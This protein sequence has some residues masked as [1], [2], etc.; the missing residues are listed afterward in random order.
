[1]QSLFHPI[2]ESSD[3]SQREDTSHLAPPCPT[4]EA[5]ECVEIELFNAIPVEVP[6]PLILTGLTEGMPKSNGFNVSVATEWCTESAAYL[7]RLLSMVV[8]LTLSFG[9]WLCA[10]LAQV[11]WNVRL[12]IV[13]VAAL[14]F[15]A[16]E[17]G[18]FLSNTSLGESFSALSELVEVSDNGVKFSFITIRLGGE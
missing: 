1:M 14:A 12:V 2:L 7:L 4:S 9:R 6:E 3:A 8:L 13:S 17:A 11:V 10:P 5:E 16:Y 15:L 18:T